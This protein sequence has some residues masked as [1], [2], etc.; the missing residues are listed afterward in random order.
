M[1]IDA[2]V[3]TVYHNEDGSGS[4]KLKA[5]D[6]KSGPAGQNRLYFD[7]APHDVTALNGREIWGGAGE[8]MVGETKIANRIGYT[9][10]EFVI[11]SFAGVF[12]GR[13]AHT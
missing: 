6:T 12:K 10:I 8:I 1:S 13:K 7:K 9:Q 3:E 11:D 2:I 4:L 5:R